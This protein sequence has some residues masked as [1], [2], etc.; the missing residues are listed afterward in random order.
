M[1]PEHTSPRRTF[2]SDN[3]A[4]V[5]PQV[6]EAIARA[7]D[8]GHTP[9]YGAD[10]W[11]TEAERL[12]HDR[13]GPDAEIYFSFNGTGAN[14]VGLQSLLRPHE[15]VVCAD[16]AHIN[17]D[18]CGAPERFLG[19]KLLGVPTPD[20][21]LTP[22]LVASAVTGIGDEHHVQARVVSITQSTEVGTVYTVDEIAALA[23]WAHAH[24]MFLHL[25]GARIANAAASLDVDLGAFGQEVGVDVL[26]FGGT[27]NGALGAEAVISFRDESE[28]GLR[29]IRKQ[30][31]QLSSK[32]RFVAAQF[33]A[34]LTDDLWRTSAEHANAMARRLAAGASAVPGVRL[35]YPVQANGVFAVL[36]PTI[37]AGL[38]SE[39]PFYVWDPTA[40]VVRWMASFDTTEDDV[41]RFVGRLAEL[42]EQHG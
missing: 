39:Y 15:A 3:W 25:D 42:M 8:G 23:R 31:M 27:K 1:S 32:M 26:S 24:A 13:F 19:S 10:P 28:T 36:P 38:Q 22:E 5:H 4:G 29:F 37:T 2:A 11:T 12:F 9:A 40:D 34:L 14:V 16:S 21:K 30:S 7:N 33:V 41:D 18:E 17:V 35:A 20:G 6:L